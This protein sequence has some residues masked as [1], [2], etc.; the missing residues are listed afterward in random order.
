[1][2]DKNKI[3]LNLVKK[4]NLTNI[5]LTMGHQKYMMILLCVGSGLSEEQAQEVIAEED[6]SLLKMEAARLSLMFPVEKE[7]VFEDLPEKQIE[8]LKRLFV[9]NQHP[10]PDVNIY[11]DLD[12]EHGG[13]TPPVKNDKRG[14]EIENIVSAIEALSKQVTDQLSCQQKDLIKGQDDI[15][16]LMQSLDEKLREQEETDESQPS[17]CPI[18]NGELPET[19]E[20]AVMAIL[21]QDTGHFSASQIRELKQIFGRGLSVE[22]AVTIARPDNS[23]EKM[24]QL[25]EFFESK[26]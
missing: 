17:F 7:D 4:N 13:S 2:T 16:H 9:E 25:I 5:K 22:E 1:M 15:R 8:E 23:V 6:T 12:E 19:A 11:E 26:K 24:K 18:V 10:E 3:F 21:M 14:E 20:E